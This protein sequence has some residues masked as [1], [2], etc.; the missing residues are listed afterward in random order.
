[1][2]RILP[3]VLAATALL[4]AAGCSR[5]PTG[6]TTPPPPAAFSGQPSLPEAANEDMGSAASITAPAE[7]LTAAHTYVRLWAR[8]DVDRDT[9]YAAVRTRVIPA[10]GRLLADT[11]P[12]NVPA[13]RVTGAARPVSSTAAVLVAEVPT[14][15]GWIRVTVVNTGGRWLIASAAPG[16][17]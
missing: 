1:M 10:Y 6:S 11:D 13:H 14:D 17:T 8:P 5:P 12:A 9:W 3:A 16:R 4:A 2:T 7:A 15:T